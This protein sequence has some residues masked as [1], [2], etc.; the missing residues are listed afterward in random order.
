MTRKINFNQKIPTSHAFLVIFVLGFLLSWFTI[1]EG[2]KIVEDGKN[3]PAFNVS[4]RM[5]INDLADDKK[6]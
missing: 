2:K 3:S 4:K 6:K 1:S 5:Q